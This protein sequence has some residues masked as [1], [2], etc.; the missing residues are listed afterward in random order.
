MCFWVSTLICTFLCS[1]LPL[2]CASSTFSSTFPCF[3]AHPLLSCALLHPS[4]FSYASLALQLTFPHLRLLPL[5][6][7]YHFLSVS[8]FQPSFL[9]P[10]APSLVFSICIYLR[11]P[12]LNL[13]DFTP[14]ISDLKELCAALPCPQHCHA[15]PQSSAL[16]PNMYLNWA[17][18]HRKLHTA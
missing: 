15:H 12:K 13:V 14:H 5:Y 6:I 9:G 4:L 11:L 2:S 3:A 17:A 1:A 18:T 10:L 16:S 8:H 7:S